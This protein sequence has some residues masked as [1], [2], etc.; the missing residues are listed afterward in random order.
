[1]V[2]RSASLAIPH[3]QSFTA[4][5]SVSLVLFGHTNRNVSLSH[6]SQREIALV[7]APSRPIPDYPNKEKFGSF[8]TG[9]FP[10]FFGKGPDCVADPFGTAAR[11]AVNRLRKRKRTNREN[12]RRVPGQIGKVPKRTKKEGQ[13]QIR[14]TPHLKPPRLEVGEKRASVLQGLCF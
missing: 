6:E 11:G 3:N 13:V 8:Q 5:P 14:K 2:R 7:E 10:T 1:M 9:E 12:P 4:I